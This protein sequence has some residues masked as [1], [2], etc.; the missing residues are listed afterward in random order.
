[1]K[2]ITQQ[3]TGTTEEWEN[4][5]PVLFEAV[6]GFEKTA[7]GK[8]YLKIGN[9]RDRWND[10]GYVDKYKIKGLA[11]ELE[12]INFDRVPGEALP[13]MDGE[14]SA[15]DPE[16]WNYSRSDHRHPRDTSRVALASDAAQI[17][18]SDIALAN[19]KKL[20]GVKKNYTQAS[21]VSVGDYGTYEQIEVG[22][23]SDPLCLNHSARAPDGTVAGKNIIVHY[24]DEAGENR[25]DAVAYESEVQALEREM[26]AW[27]GR[28]GFLDEYDF[29]T[30]TPTQE[31]LTAYALSQIPSISD[32]TDIWNGTK[33]KN[34]YNGHTWIL[35]NSQDT[36]PAVFEWTD[37]GAIDLSGFTNTAGGYIKGDSERSGHIK[38]QSDYT[39]KVNGWDELPGKLFDLL[40][41]VGSS[42]VQHLNDPAPEEMGWPGAW[43]QWSHRADAYRLSDSP[44]PLCIS[45][46]EGLSCAAG[47]CVLWHLD[48]D[49]WRY[50][51]AKE[52]ITNAPE[53]LDPAKWDAVVQGD[54]VERRFVHDWTEY[55]LMPGEQVEDGDYTG[56]YVT[57]VIVPGG[58]FFGVEGGFRPPFV[59]GGVQE[60]RIINIQGSIASPHSSYGSFIGGGIAGGA[61]EVTREFNNG[62]EFKN[63]NNTF[64]IDFSA[65]RVVPT[66]PDNAPANLS[67]RIWRRVG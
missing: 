48:N 2:A 15:G 62:A 59:S 54:V 34:I 63:S 50:Y 43:E 23:E 13:E 39:G 10:L 26:D 30:E 49:D 47:E 44:P 37:Q 28:G 9:G 57:E 65:D 52:A 61:F 6:W 41:P 5:N 64:D 55:D 4:E 1:V 29:G 7:D 60:G 42:Y 40:K 8:T 35:T 3:Y 21:L 18:D 53:Y 31:A 16:N 67:T 58:K 36:Q 19:G 46:Y 33:V 27:I 20:L 56:K 11:E 45:Y 25:A 66:G 22:T 12:H 14:G 51:T 24:K 17:I 32:P 38:A